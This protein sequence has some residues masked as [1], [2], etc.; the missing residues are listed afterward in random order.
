MGLRATTS[1]IGV[2][3]LRQLGRSLSRDPCDGSHPIVGRTVYPPGW[4]VPGRWSSY[5]S[6][7]PRGGVVLSVQRGI[8]LTSDRAEMTTVILVL[9][10]S[11][12]RA[13]SCQGRLAWQG[14]T[15][16]YLFWWSWR[17]EVVR[18]ASVVRPRQVK[19]VVDNPDLGASPDLFGF[20]WASVVWA[21]VCCCVVSYAA[22]HLID[23]LRYPGVI[24]TIVALERFCDHEM[25]IKALVCA[26]S[27]S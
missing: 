5:P 21:F 6:L 22:R 13:C 16:F 1:I 8:G 23:A 25:I 14:A 26:Y 3:A 15:S 27:W 7:P 2:G 9:M 18:L 4:V 17:R 12:R 11:V 24:T 10:G 19:G 20:C